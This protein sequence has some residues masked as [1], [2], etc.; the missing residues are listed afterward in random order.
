MASV[1]LP[2]NIHLDERNKVAGPGFIN[3]ICI[4]CVKKRN[5]SITTI[6]I[7]RN[8][9][10]VLWVNFPKEQIHLLRVRS[11]FITPRWVGLFITCTVTTKVKCLDPVN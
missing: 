3:S 6:F 11:K 2:S 7:L 4:N 10:I 8:T 5:V 1:D 9:D